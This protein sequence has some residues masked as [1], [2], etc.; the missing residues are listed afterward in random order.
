MVWK[1]AVQVPELEMEVKAVAVWWLFQDI[2]QVPNWK[3][4]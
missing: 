3:A 2:A 4:Q 1:E